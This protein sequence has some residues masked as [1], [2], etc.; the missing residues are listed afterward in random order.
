VPFKE[1]PRSLPVAVV[2]TSAFAVGLWYGP[3]SF[4]S[5]VSLT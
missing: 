2:T 3:I 5:D 4:T 1:S